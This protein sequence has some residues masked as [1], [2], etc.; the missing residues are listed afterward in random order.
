MSKND[1][2]N[3]EERRRK[4]TC[5]KTIKIDQLKKSM[6]KGKVVTNTE[7]SWG[8]QDNPMVMD[9]I[10][11]T[12]PLQ[13]IQEINEDKRSG[14]TSLPTKNYHNAQIQRFTED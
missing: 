8:Q 6:D 13:E 14:I 5:M 1:F 11:F 12:T 10:M 9:D 3:Y 7:E 2:R 4:I